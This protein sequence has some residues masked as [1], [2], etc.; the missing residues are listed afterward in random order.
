MAETTATSEF[1]IEKL[2]TDYMTWATLFQAMLEDKML[3][4]AISE[5]APDVATDPTGHAEWKKKDRRALARIKMGVALHHLPTVSACASAKVAWDALESMFSAQNATRR[6][7]LGRELAELRIKSGE[8]VLAYSGRV[9]RLHAQLVGAGHPIDETTAIIHFLK[10]LPD[11]HA[12]EKKL[13]TNQ[14]GD[15]LR[16]ATTL[17]MLYP[18]EETIKDKAA[19][20]EGPSTGAFGAWP[21][22][23]P[24]PRSERKRRVVCWNCNTRGHYAAECTANPNRPSGSGGG[25]SASF[26][27]TAK[28]VR[29]ANRSAGAI[30]T[31]SCSCG[32]SQGASISTASTAAARL[33]NAD[34]WLVDSG[35]SNNMQKT[36][37]NMT[38]YTPSANSVTIASGDALPSPGHGS[39]TLNTSLGGTLTLF[40]TLHVP[41][42][43][44]N[45]FSVRAVDRGGGKVTFENDGVKVEKDGVVLATGVVNSNEQYILST[46]KPAASG[47][48]AA[49]ASAAAAYGMASEKGNLWHRRFCHLGNANVAKVAKLVTGMD[50]T[51]NDTTTM[52]G[53]V[54]EPCVGA[55]MATESFED[56]DNTISEPLEMLCVD[57]IGPLTPSTG[58]AV[59]AL[60]LLDVSTEMSFAS[61]LKTKAEASKALRD[62]VTHLELQSGRKVKII[63]ADGARE[64]LGRAEVR[65]FMQEKGIKAEPTAPYTPQQNGKAERLNRTLMERV[66]AMILDAGLAMDTWGEALMAAEYTRNRSPTRDGKSTPFERFYGKKPNVSNLRVWG[67]K[68]WARNRPKSHGKLESMTLV[69]HVV[70]Y[71]AGEHAWRIRSATTSHILIRRDVVVDESMSAA[72]V[73]PSALPVCLFLPD[74]WA[75]SSTGS[76]A[77]DAGDDGGAGPADTTDLKPGSLDTPPAPRSAPDVTA[78]LP[79]HGYFLRLRPDADKPLAFPM[80]HLAV[81]RPSNPDAL[82]RTGAIVN[83]AQ[84]LAA[85]ALPVPLTVSFATASPMH[86]P[87]RAEEA[88]KRADWIPT[89][90]T[91]RADAL[92]RPDA[93]LWQ[94]AMD[95]E[96]NSMVENNVWS[97]RPLP[98]GANKMKGKWVFDYKKDAGGVFVRYKARFVGCGYS[99]RAGV[100]YH[101]VWAPCPARATVK[102]VLASAAA[103][104]LEIHSIDVKTAYLNAPMEV[105]VYVEQPEGYT[106]GDAGHVAELHAALYGTKQA[107][108]LWGEHLHGTLTAAGARRATADPTLFLWDHPEHGRIIFLAH[109]DDILVLAKSPAGVADAKGVVLVR[110]KGRDMGPAQEFLGMRIVRARPARALSL[111]SPGLTKALVSDYGLTHANPNKLPMPV[112]VE[113]QRTG[114]DVMENSIQYQELVGRLMYLSSS[115]RP[116]IAYAAATLARYMHQPEE[117]HWRIAKGVIRY[118]AGTVDLCLQYDGSGELEGA[119]DA[120]YNGCKDSRRSTTGW[121]FT[122]KGGTISLSS[123]RQPTVSSS[124]AEAEYVAAAAATR[125]A[126]WLRKLMADLGEKDRAVPIAEDNQACLALIAN[127][128][129]T[130]RAKNIDTAHHLVRER[131]AM[132][133]V[134]F[135]YRPGAEMVADGMT[136]AL[137]APALQAF[138]E[139]LG[140]AGSGVPTPSAE[141][142]D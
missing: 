90:P 64:L 47:P 125:E 122:Y 92:S 12:M 26:M 130:G 97:I 73:N 25:P 142:I 31:C 13:L 129:G 7:H 17:P 79:G 108:R 21:R 119:V 45:L 89:P 141:P 62:W 8:S 53:A 74:E 37:A 75:D 23:T 105:P 126:L 24:M 68:A 54:R 59:H 40:N 5:E 30:C 19:A 60:S 99:Q 112:G 137:P 116:D 128:E 84:P 132:G 66:R 29:F 118:L 124:T 91:S 57:L 131:T 123:K 127:P 87:M 70:G 43:T 61:L 98:V 71:S 95:D 49:T 94:E 109:V 33:T 136:K 121:V 77:S 110:Y 55:R 14:G 113:V 44:A 115:T 34:E 63:R 103:N 36:D 140:M 15:V 20:I 81:G 107:G 133:A 106:V 76:A 134:K 41:D 2:D 50:L 10:G 4:E 86:E 82:R 1:H 35:S 16:W 9:K 93:Y 39:V 58:G 27:A 114:E 38:S 101:E 65:A 102:A 117:K 46:T 42:I 100:D 6:L 88:V 48:S 111:S 78:A 22:N 52:L 138:R 32:A 28:T 135:Y 83:R 104:D 69:G 139:K 96:Y 3:W 85:V 56:A 72:P 67:S 11:D 51:T 80:A 120:D 18:V